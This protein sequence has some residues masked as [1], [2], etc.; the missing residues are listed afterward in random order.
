M[1]NSSGIVP[2]PVKTHVVLTQ[3]RLYGVEMEF[4]GDVHG[5]GY[6]DL[7][8]SELYAS[9]PVLHMGKVHMWA[10][11]ANGPVSNW[12]ETGPFANALL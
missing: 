5:D 10:G 12:S 6:D 9:T 8:V 1:G 4:V 2:V 11:S 3:G 7:L